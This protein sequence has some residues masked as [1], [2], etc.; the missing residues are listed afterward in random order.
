[1]VEENK[2]KSQHYVP[3]VYLKNFATLNNKIYSFYCFDKKEE[4][5]LSNVNIKKIA[6]ED[7]FYDKILEEQE[8]E[9]ILRNIESK[10]DLI[11]QELILTKDIERLTE[12]KK[13]ILSRFIS[14]QM[15]RTKETRQEI[16]EL[17]KQIYEKFGDQMIPSLKK[18][19]VGAMQEDSIRKIHGDII[20]EIEENNKIIKNLKWILVINKTPFPFWTSDNPVV[21]HNEINL[22]PY[23]NLGLKCVGIEI[24]IPL[25]PKLSLTICDPRIFQNKPIKENITDLRRIIRERCYQVNQSTRFIFS[26]E[27]KFDLA[28]VMVKNNSLLKDPNRRRTKIN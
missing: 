9:K 27:N 11:I 28:K 25:N 8:T 20:K 21:L 26:I 2:V 18:Q 23:G 12:D 6:F 15:V 24:H 5:I 3:R 1:M 22:A 19:I 13:D 14:Y 10:I 4:K 7:E 17:P 16:S